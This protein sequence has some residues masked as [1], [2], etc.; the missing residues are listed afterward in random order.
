MPELIKTVVTEK[1]VTTVLV[2]TDQEKTVSEDADIEDTGG[3][4]G[5]E[6]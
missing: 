1:L 6:V 2:V 3:L 5:R 4:L